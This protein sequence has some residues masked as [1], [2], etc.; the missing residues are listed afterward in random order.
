MA[1]EVSDVVWG[2]HQALEERMYAMG[3]DAALF[4]WLDGGVGK[5]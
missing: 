5:A 2:N 3:A 4:E 1:R